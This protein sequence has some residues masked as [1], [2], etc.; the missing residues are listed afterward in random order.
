MNKSIRGWVV[1]F[2][3]ISG[4]FVLCGSGGLVIANTFKINEINSFGFFAAFGVVSVAYL[5]APKH[6]ISSSVIVFLLGA[7]IAWHLL[8]D[9]N[10]YG[11]SASHFLNEKHTSFLITTLGGLLSLFI[12]LFP[13][14]VKK[15]KD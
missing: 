2:F 1:F 12:C 11:D 13:F 10:N 5:S 9:T 14:V 8:K 7:F 3:A 15:G 4:A 6:P